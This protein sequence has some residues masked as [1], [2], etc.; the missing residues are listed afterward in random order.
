MQKIEGE[1]A[2]KIWDKIKKENAENADLLLSIKKS[3]AV[4][5]GKE[6]FDYLKLQQLVD[7]SRWSIS[8]LE[9]MYYLEHPSFMT[10]QDLADSLEESWRWRD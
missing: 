9:S 4:K 3:E 10:M 7:T 2:E 6:I 5:N 8:R 1:A